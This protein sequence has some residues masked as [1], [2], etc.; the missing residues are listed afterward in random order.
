MPGFRI[1]CAEVKTPFIYL[2][3]EYIVYRPHNTGDFVIFR[4]PQLRKD[5]QSSL[6]EIISLIS[7]INSAVQDLESANEKTDQ[8]LGQYLT[9]F[10]RIQNIGE[11]IGTIIVIDEENYKACIEVGHFIRLKIQNNPLAIQIYLE[12]IKKFPYISE[13]YRILCDIYFYDFNAIW[14]FPFLKHAV[15]KF[16]DPEFVIHPTLGIDPIFVCMSYTYIG[17]LY[18]RIGKI[19][20]A[21]SAYNIVTETW[22]GE[23]RDI[24]ALA[25]YSNAELDFICGICSLDLSFGVLTENP[26][27]NSKE[28]PKLV[29]TSVFFGKVYTKLFIDGAMKTFFCETNLQ[30]IKKYWD[31][32]L[33]LFCPRADRYA[34]ENSDIFRKIDTI[35]NIQFITFPKSLLRLY[36]DRPEKGEPFHP[37][38]AYS[39]AA[40]SQLCGAELARRYS[41]DFINLPPDCIFSNEAA[42][43]I[44]RTAKNDK[45][46]ILF[47]PGIRLNR[48]AVSENYLNK[49]N[50]TTGVSPRQLLEI[51]MQNIHPATKATFATNPKVTHPGMLWWPAGKTGLVGHCFQMHPIFVG[52]KI[53]QKG[54]FRRFDSIDGDFIHSLIPN[55]DDWELI[56]V[57][58]P[59]N[60]SM[61][62]EL[63]G[64]EI[65]PNCDYLSNTLPGNAKRW[66]THVM[67][68]LN[69]WLFQ[70][71]IHIGNTK[72]KWT[73]KNRKHAEEIKLGVGQLSDDVA[74]K[75]EQTPPSVVEEQINQHAALVD[76]WNAHETKERGKEQTY[77]RA[78]K[79]RYEE[80][81]ED[82]RIIF[83][84][85]LWGADYVDNFLNFCLPSMLAEGNLADLP[86][87]VISTVEIR[88]TPDDQRILQ[89][90]RKFQYLEKIINVV[91]V[92]IA[93]YVDDANKYSTLSQGQ[94]N[95]IQTIRS[96][97]KSLSG[98]EYIFHYDVIFF[99][100][101]DFVWAKGAIKNTLKRLAAGY[102]GVLTPVPPLVLE[103]FQDLLI[104]AQAQQNSSLLDE[105]EGKS[106]YLY[107]EGAGRKG[108]DPTKEKWLSYR[109]FGYSID[110]SP[111]ELVRLGKPILH[112][113]MRDNI[114]DYEMHSG[115]P[116]YVL[117]LGPNDDLLIRCFHAHPVAVR[118]Q[119]ENP[120]FWSH[121]HKTLDEVFLPQVFTSLDRLHYVEDSDEIAIVSLTEAAFPV[122]IMPKNHFLDATFIARWAEAVAAPLHKYMFN[123]HT[124]WHSEDI[125]KEAWKHTTTRSALTADEVQFKLSL[126]GILSLEDPLYFGVREQRRETFQAELNSINKYK[127]QMA[128]ENRTFKTLW[129][130]FTLGFSRF[131]YKALRVIFSPFGTG[132]KKLLRSVMPKRLNRWIE[133]RHWHD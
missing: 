74:V 111:R 46:E 132:I 70:H 130:S 38:Q 104:Q 58:S 125:E 116:A 119:Q 109:D 53:L 83:S 5:S 88:T 131:L 106:S 98:D 128:R 110:L 1:F 71:E 108:T 114:I 133:F 79:K 68:P 100:Y 67:R 121:F 21:R 113:M 80:K 42:G 29:L 95:C 22:S 6:K 124:F 127:K 92:D 84:L 36:P 107:E 91:F 87:N 7:K 27:I 32:V 41:A 19:W 99:L 20:D 18:E 115:N 47:T 51:C 15:E 23:H 13:I 82:L 56:E 120:L 43:K 105:G 97:N 76:F 16:S 44:I 3:S 86:N 37:V 117:W 89:Q 62:F 48:N 61:M 9:D 75:I 26:K 93:P 10:E 25:A 54:T 45:K 64:E 63:S 81:A 24:A 30:E 39:I 65:S 77:V 35:F 55:S 72:E 129:H 78:N 49:I 12:I 31:P 73:T 33:I 122:P 66:L 50:R 101:A 118:V 57:D 14:H 112:P 90:N 34:V 28:K 123:R 96:K 4:K 126:P 52:R 11:Q 94:S 40:L 8:I 59:G 69:F 17:R 85:V 2:R 103:S 60:E 102:E